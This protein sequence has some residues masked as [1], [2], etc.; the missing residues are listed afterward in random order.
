MRA[1][2]A[3][4]H[5]GPRRLRA[6][7]VRV[8]VEEQQPVLPRPGLK[9]R[10]S[11]VGR[12]RAF[13][14]LAVHVLIAL[15]V[16]HWLSNGTT[17]SPLE[18]SESMEFAR[19]G[20]LNA[21]AIFFGLAILSTL[22]LGRWFCGWACHI[23]AVQDAARWLLRR[24]GWNP[25]ELDLGP[26]AAVPWLAAVYMF[27]AP[28]AVRLL[29]QGGLAPTDVH[30]ATEDFWKT[31]PDW[32][33]ALLTLAV[34]GGL[35]V[36]LLGSKGFC[37]YACPYGGLFGVADQL[38][39]WRIRVGSNCNGCGHCTVVCTSNVKVHA[40]VRDHG[41][42]VDPGCMK[43]MD[44]VS[45]CPNGALRF[46]FG[47]PAW[48]TKAKDGAQRA[49]RKLDWGREALA[50]G[51]ALAAL[52]MFHW[53][54]SSASAYVNSPDWGVVAAIAGAA[55]LV[56]LVFRSRAAKRRETM[57]GEELL[58]G[59]VF[60]ASM[61]AFRGLHDWVPFLLCLGVSSIVASLALSAKRMLLSREHA[62]QRWTLK[63][64]GAATGPGKVFLAACVLVFGGA[65]W[66]AQQQWTLAQA[67]R[68]STAAAA[69]Q[70]HGAREAYN[71]GVAAAQAGDMVQAVQEFAE[72][73]RLDPAFDE[74]RDNL[75][76]ALCAVGRLDE[77]LALFEEAL[78][79]RPEDLDTRMLALRAALQLG[80][81]DAAR[82][83]LDA[84]LR[85]RPGDAELK[86][87]DAELARRGGGR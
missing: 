49:V 28:A 64:N 5:G 26:L 72:A 21:G 48:F 19:K 65:A 20:L 61:Y 9:V 4:T 85:Q 11:Q 73:R 15:H 62:L 74:A 42:V 66:A 29:V 6:R 41:T 82:S 86:A 50:L 44:C 60:V 79:E 43:C 38:A 3:G 53:Y 58:L 10:P 14:L 34:S 81:L 45:S 25:R 67:A 18:P 77:G 16:A 2:S 24:A 57:R 33:V 35:T 54:D 30:L 59:A 23:V 51:F 13:A 31:F 87:L 71:R 78:R 17:L 7:I 70:V 46:G 37:S 80:R 8:Q 1:G 40:E 84:A 63:K 76:G 55:W 69:Q 68:A 36:L 39:P 83:H 12:W 27:L 56:G 52:A 32:P 47:M 22:V 75:A